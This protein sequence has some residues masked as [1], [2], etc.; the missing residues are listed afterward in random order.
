MRARRV[1]FTW[2]FPLDNKNNWLRRVKGGEIACWLQHGGPLGC[3]CFLKGGS[4]HDCVIA[5]AY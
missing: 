2:M 4:E 1:E 5:A 3:E